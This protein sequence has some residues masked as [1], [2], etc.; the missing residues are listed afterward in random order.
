MA[1]A[2][3]A[4]RRDVP[5]IAALPE[6][7]LIGRACCFLC[8]VLMPPAGALL[9]LYLALAGA[10][11][12]WW[13]ER[14]VPREQAEIL[15]ERV[16]RG[17]ATELH[18]GRD[19]DQ[20]WTVSISDEQANAWLAQG[21]SRWLRNRRIEWAERV[22]DL[23]AAFED[24][25]VRV[26]ARTDARVLSAAFNLRIDP[27]G[28]LWATPSQIAAGSLRLP[29]SWARSRA[30]D[31]LERYAQDD[32]ARVREALEGRAPILDRPVFDLGD[33]RRVRVVEIEPEPGRLLITCVTE[34]P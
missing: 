28:A 11:P 26:G 15:A 34:R 14:A 30:M 22:P 8:I 3:A 2:S 33:G 4:R 27:E 12:S 1:P 5:L 7:R 19:A 13:A 10:T 23:R 9:L 6:L 18:R 21:L 32:A 29:D 16:E 24:G 20:P 17:V 25:S 31:A